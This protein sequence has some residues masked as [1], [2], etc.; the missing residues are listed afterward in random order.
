MFMVKTDALNQ[1]MINNYYTSR[2]SKL[3][4]D[5]NKI[6]KRARKVFVCH[7]GSDLT[8]TIAEETRQEFENLIPELPYIGDK[9]SFFTKN[10]IGSAQA[11]ALYRVLKEH[12]KNV[13]EIGKIIY[14]VIEAQLDAY[15]K[16][17]LRLLGRLS[18][19]KYFVNRFRKKAAESQ[20][21]QYP[22]DWVFTFIEGDGIE[23]D[24]GI[25]FSECGICKFLHAQ[26]ADELTPFLC[27][28]DFPQSKALG[29]GLVRTMTIAE[30]NEKCDFRFKRGREV[31]Q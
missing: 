27:I 29:T 9:N 21:R 14:E 5:F 8:Y 18:F 12:G 1:Q 10:L 25:D 7:F 26:D 22:G 13:E 3:L 4:K 24:Y 2:K 20:K 11:L 16:L 17:L 23:F 6:I 19:A 15:P 31:R 30:G 28:L